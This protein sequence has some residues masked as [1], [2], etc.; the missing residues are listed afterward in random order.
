MGRNCL[1]HAMTFMAAAAALVS[2]CAMANFGSIRSSAD[3]TRQFEA[4]EINPNFRY[5][6]LNQENNRD[7]SALASRSGWPLECV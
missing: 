2:G 3:V 1:R 5:W 6:Y 7:R 4:V